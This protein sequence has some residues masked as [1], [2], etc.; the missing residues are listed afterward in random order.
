M[1]ETSSVAVMTRVRP[2]NWRELKISRDK[3]EQFPN[4]VVQMNDNTVSIVEH[5]RAA[6]I[7]VV[8]RAERSIDEVNAD[9]ARALAQA[10]A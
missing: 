6:D 3:G 2:F 7:L 5:Y 1:S 9:L 4:C 8:I 10:V